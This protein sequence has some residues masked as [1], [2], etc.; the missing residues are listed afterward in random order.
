LFLKELI[1]N[2]LSVLERSLIDKI[3]NISCHPPALFKKRTP[4]LDSLL[5]VGVSQELMSITKEFD[6]GLHSLLDFIKEYETIGK[7]QTVNQI[8]EQFCVAVLEMLK[9]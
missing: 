3:P 9:R 8:R 2:D 7:E 5:A 6:D 4:K 1:N